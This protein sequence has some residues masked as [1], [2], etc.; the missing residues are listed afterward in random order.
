MQDANAAANISSGTQKPSFPPNAGG[1]L[2]VAMCCPFTLKSHSVP[3]FQVAVPSKFI[4]GTKTLPKNS[5]ETNKFNT[6][7]NRKTKEQT[8]KIAKMQQVKKG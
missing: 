4:S 6:Y 8:A 1:G 5:D 7:G 3:L 2:T